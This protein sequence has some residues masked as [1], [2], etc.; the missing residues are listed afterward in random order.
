MKFEKYIKILTSISRPSGAGSVAM[1]G[2]ASKRI[3]DVK[4]F[5]TSKQISAIIKRHYKKS[6][7][8][9]VP[10]G[11]ITGYHFM[12]AERKYTAFDVDGSVIEV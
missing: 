3:I 9:C 10:F 2:L 7:G 1:T 5:S 4:Q 8:K 6:R 11:N 12:T